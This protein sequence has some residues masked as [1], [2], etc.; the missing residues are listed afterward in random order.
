MSDKRD[1]SGILF[2]ND[3]KEK[4]SHPDY[5][6]NCTINGVESPTKF[7]FDDERLHD[8]NR[9]I[10]LFRRDKL[11]TQDIATLMGISEGKVQSLLNTARHFRL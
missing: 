8:A 2:K 3:R 9:A 4:D 11:D 5:T 7:L 6:G 10:T 1:Y